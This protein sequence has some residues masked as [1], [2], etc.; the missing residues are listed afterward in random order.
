MNA[1]TVYQRT[2]TRGKK[3]GATGFTTKFAVER[4]D[5][6]ALAKAITFDN[7]PAKYKDSYKTAKI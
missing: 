5:I 7:C 4:G 1:I 6:K 3:A 2:G